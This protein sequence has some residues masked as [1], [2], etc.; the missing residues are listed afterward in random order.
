[1]SWM[2]PYRDEVVLY[3]HHGG[4]VKW[5][6]GIVEYKGGQVDDFGVLQEYLSYAMLKKVGT[7][8]LGYDWVERMLLRWEM[9][10]YFI[11]VGTSITKTLG[12]TW[13]NCHR[14]RRCPGDDFEESIGVGGLIHLVED[15]D[16][17]TDPEFIEAMENLGVLGLRRAFH[18]LR[19]ADGE[20]VDQLYTEIAHLEQEAN[21]GE[22]E[23]EVGLDEVS[24]GDSPAFNLADENSSNSGSDS[25]DEGIP[26][27]NEDVPPA[28][29]N[30]EHEFQGQDNQA[31]PISSYR[32]SSYSDH[33][34]I[35]LSDD[36]VISPFERQPWYDPNC[37]HKTLVLV[38]GLRFTGPRKFKDVV[39]DYCIA[40]LIDVYWVRSSQRKMKAICR[41]SCGWRVY[42]SL[43]GWN[44]AFVVKSVGDPHLCTRA[45]VIK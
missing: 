29:A 14:V 33:D 16:R 40:A 39:I 22:D 32:G 3:V 12:T 27:G 35:N 28:A 13:R 45:L 25:D 18:S 19:C 9:C 4:H 24:D 31:S 34:R 2:E 36:E 20:E 38:K 23:V 15:S 8:H 41:S 37:D 5:N 42:A 10:I 11:C 30:V 44:R 21:V 17:T 7:E 1:M 6:N 43:Y 26:E